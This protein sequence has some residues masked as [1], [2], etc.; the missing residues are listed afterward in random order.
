MP[1]SLFTKFKS[2]TYVTDNICL[3]VKSYSQGCVSK[4]ICGKSKGDIVEVSKSLGSFSLDILN[5]RE[6]FLLIAGG[7]GIT[8]LLNLLLFLLERRIRK[9]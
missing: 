4:Y 7:T 9:W 6:T 3:L 5:N 2:Q 1:N 8:P